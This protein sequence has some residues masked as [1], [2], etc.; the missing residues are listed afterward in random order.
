MGYP[1]GGMYNNG[2]YDQPYY[3]DYNQLGSPYAGNMYGGGAM[4]SWGDPY[5]GRRNNRI[6]GSLFG[7]SSGRRYSSPQLSYDQL[8]QEQ[9]RSLRRNSRSHSNQSPYKHRS[10]HSYSDGKRRS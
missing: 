8:Q 3:M 7:T 6:F 10:R 1:Q 9:L 4:R 2:Y 5:Y